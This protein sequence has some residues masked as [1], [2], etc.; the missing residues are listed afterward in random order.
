MTGA[1]LAQV[2]LLPLVP[3]LP[4]VLL[5][6]LW[7]RR[8]TATALRLVP[9]A[10]LPGLLLVLLPPSEAVFELPWMLLG[11]SLGLD[12]AGRLFLFLFSLLW[13]AAGLY[14]RGYLREDP[15]QR[16]FFAFFL[17]AM[18]GNLGMPIARD[19]LDFYLFFAMMSFSAYGL[20]VH[21]SSEFALRA[22]RI[23]LYLVLVSE[24]V[25]FVALVLAAQAGQSLALAD[26]AVA[27][28]L[29][30]ER[31]LIMALLLVGFGIKMG[32]VPLHVWLPL[33]HPAAP[34]PASAV[35]S[36]AMIKA[37]L[38]GLLRF[39]PLGE[40]ALPGWSLV[41]I[42]L[43]LAMAFFGVL[44]GLAQHQAKAVL[45][46]SSISQMGFPLLGLGLAL[47]APQSWPLL[48]PVILLYAL[49]H[50]LA[51]GALFL[52]VG[53]AGELTVSTR[54]RYLV[55]G[56]LLLPALALAGAPLTSGALAKGALKPLVSMA[57]GGWAELLPWLLSLG[58]IGTTLLMARFLAVLWPRS[59]ARQAPR[60]LMWSGWGLLILGV[61]LCRDGR[62]PDFIGV[63]ATPGGFSYGL[64]DALWPVAVGALV[65]AAA[66]LR[67][68]RRGGEAAALLPP[69]ELLLVLRKFMQPLTQLARRL[70]VDVLPRRLK[71]RAPPGVRWHNLAL[72][73]S[74]HEAEQALRRLPT[75]GLV[76][77][78]VLLLLLTL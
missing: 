45:A 57:P 73:L 18:C 65:A 66:W 78:I 53:M 13:M 31:N 58:A 48:A 33:A 50:G 46:Y 64:W 8:C 27:I 44:A 40:V 67:L 39:L 37:G 60:P 34:I 11:G 71:W 7:F 21:D 59:A 52:G 25:L 3:L 61:L 68:P 16:R 17:L 42:L 28:A 51:K 26:A 19:M 12:P 74:L 55:L 10:P 5:T 36:G 15:R 72:L 63:T 22:G 76:F 23:Y 9:W 14:A 43:G 69:G 70:H 32:V 4:L 29:A 35:L 6:V 30:P 41:F 77:L 62:L 54:R 2:G 24:V 49:H 38:L 56:G 20:V 47:A 1:G 75:A